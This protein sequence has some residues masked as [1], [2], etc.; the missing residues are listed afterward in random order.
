MAVLCFINILL[1]VSKTHK[2][3][4]LLDIKRNKSADLILD[5]M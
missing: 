5:D 3:L 2:D 4:Q 1:A